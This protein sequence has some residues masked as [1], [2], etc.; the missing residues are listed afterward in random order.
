MPSDQSKS[1]ALGK[2][3][4]RIAGKGRA[5]DETRA[6]TCG[7]SF[8][9]FSGKKMGGSGDGSP[10]SAGKRSKHTPPDLPSKSWFGAG[11]GHDT[12]TARTPA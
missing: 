8:Y 7:A 10:V 6:L 12:C 5:E 1:R 3:I 4:F 11:E 2:S 9:H